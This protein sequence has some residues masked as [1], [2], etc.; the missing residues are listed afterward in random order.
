MPVFVWLIG[1]NLDIDTKQNN[2]GRKDTQLAL[3]PPNSLPPSIPERQ[4]HNFI[5]LYE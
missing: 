2:S 1:S 4:E 3:N 5:N